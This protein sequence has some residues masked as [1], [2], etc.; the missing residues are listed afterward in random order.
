V[1]LESKKLIRSGGS[2]T[3]GT[4]VPSKSIFRFK[5]FESGFLGDGV[6]SAV[7]F[8]KDLDVF[9]ELKKIA[10]SFEDNL[11]A[12]NAAIFEDD[13]VADKNEGDG[14]LSRFPDRTSRDS[15]EGSRFDASIFFFLPM[16]AFVRHSLVADRRLFDFAMILDVLF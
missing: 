16:F 15:N 2:F 13:V 8:D 10:L 1:I 5:V 4:T 14:D 6:H 12:A 7:S 11:D 3:R 9:F